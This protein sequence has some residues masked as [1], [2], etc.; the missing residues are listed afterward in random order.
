MTIQEAAAYQTIIS[1]MS[2]NMEMSPSLLR[3]VVIRV[4]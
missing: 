3:T 2:M 1:S 4:L